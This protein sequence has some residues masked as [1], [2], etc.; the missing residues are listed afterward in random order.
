[1]NDRAPEPVVWRRLFGGASH[2]L[3]LAVL[4]VIAD[5]VT[6]SWINATLRLYERVPVL[7]FLDIVHLR[8]EGAAFSILADAAGWQRWFFIV[9]AVAVSV[10]IVVWLRRLPRRGQTRLAVG[11]VLVLGGAVGN[12]VDRV[13]H[14]AVI[15]F[16]Y[17]YWGTWYFPAFNVA[18]TAITIGAGLL[19]LD[20][21]LAGRAE[22]RAA[23]QQAPDATGHGAH[24]IEQ[25]AGK[26]AGKDAG[27]DAGKAAGK[28]A[29]QGAGK[30]TGDGSADAGDTGRRN[31]N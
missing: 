2:W 30:S 9:L 16:V 13:V 19:I 3:W 8:N 5:Q 20:T 24:G 7:D 14:G 29:D 6:K 21:L 11:L 31:G 12:V 15:D 23:A 25:G 4:V 18:D 28:A 22:K 26:A 27:K 1:M 17:F 10:A